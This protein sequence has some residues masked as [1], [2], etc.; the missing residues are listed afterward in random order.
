MNQKKVGS[1]FRLYMLLIGLL[2]TGTAW[3]QL[4]TGESP[5]FPDVPPRASLIQISEPNAAQ[6]VTV[7]GAAGAVPGGN[8]VV[9]VT[10]DTGHMIQVMAGSDGSFSA[11][12]FAPPGTSIL[13]KTGPSLS[14]GDSILVALAGTILRVADPQFSGGGISFGGAGPVDSGTLPVWTFQGT[15]NSNRLQPG[16]AL[17][18]GGTLRIASEALRDASA[19][20][21]QVG[22]SMERLSGPDGVGSLAKNLYSSVF[23]TPTGLPIEMTYNG[24]FTPLSQ[25][26]VL[27]L[28]KVE[29]DK[30][31]AIADLL[32][33]L[34][35]DLPAGYYRPYVA[36]SFEGVPAQEAPNITLIGVDAAGRVPFNN[37]NIRIS[38]YLPIVRIGEPA[39]PGL[40]WALLTDTL[41]NGTRGVRAIEDRGRFG[42]ASRILTQSE[43]FIVPRADAATGEPFTYRLEPFLPTISLGDRGTPPNPPLI[44][45]RIPSGSLTTRIRKPDGSVDT[46]GPAPFVQARVRGPVDSGGTALGR[47]G[48]HITDAYQLS[49]MDPSFEV[50]FTQEGRHVITLEGS[51]EDV[52]GNTW[53][54][55]GTY[56]VYVARILSLDTAVLPGTPFEAGNFF[57]SGL[58]VQ[59][60]VPAE[61]E[62]RFRLAPHSD[63]TQA[64]ERIVR[65]RANRLGYYL[66]A[67]GELLLDQPGEYRVDLKASYRDEQGSLWMGARSWGGVVA[68]RNPAIIA[69]GRRGV[70][71]QPEIGAQ[72]FFRTETGIPIGSSHVPYAFHTGDV[73]WLQGSDAVIPIVTFQDT[74][75]SF[76]DL[77]TGRLHPPAEG[78][79]SIEE[80]ATAGEVQLFSSRPDGLDPQ[81]DPS[82]VDLWGYFYASVQRPLVRVREEIRQEMAATG[83]YW[84]FNE[85]FGGQAGVGRNGDLPND[86]KFQYGA[87]VLRGAALEEPQYA[88]YAS[89]F[90]LIPDDD[91]S[92]GT[93]TFPPFQG[94][95]GGPSGG[96]VMTLK[97]REIDIFFHPTGVRPGS[98]LEAGGIASFAG[99]IA[100][101]LPSKVE[102]TITAPGGEIREV[103]GQANKIGYFYDPDM[104]FIVEEAGP[105]RVKVKVWHDGLTSA[106]PV[107]EPFPAG[108]VLGASQGEFFFYVVEP[109]SEELQVGIARNSFVRPAEGPIQ[110]SISP[111]QEPLEAVEASRLQNAE[112]HFTTVMPGFILEEG[113]STELSYSYDAPRLH[114]DFPNLDLFDS[115]G[116]AGADTVT[117]SFLI[118]GT[119]SQGEMVYQARQL[120]LQGEELMALP[121]RLP[122]EGFAQFGDGQGLS[123][124]LILVNP[125]PLQTALGKAELV[126]SEGGAL[127]ADINGESGKSRFSFEVSPLGA[128][129][130]QTDGEGDLISGSALL[131]SNIPLGGTVLFSGDLGVAGVGMVRP[132][133]HFTVPLE[134]QASQGVETGLALANPADA[135]VVVEVVLR[136][137]DGSQIGRSNLT[138]AARGQLAKFP[139]EIFPGTDLSS[140]RGSLQV[141]SPQPIIGMAIRVSPGQFATLPVASPAGGPTTRRFAQFGDGDGISSTM[142]LVN[143]FEEETSGT[144]RL[145]ASDGSPLLVEINGKPVEGAFSFSLPARGVAFFAGDGAGDLAAGWV[146]VESDLQIG[147]TIL[148]AGGFGV[149]GVGSVEAARRFLLPVESDPGSE[150]QTG[151]ALANPQDSAVEVAL[152]LRGE[153]GKPITGGSASLSL[154]ARGQLAQFP[155]EI[156]DAQLIDL[157]NFRGTLEVSASQPVVGMA[158][159]VSPGE[160]AT[161]PVTRMN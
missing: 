142:I 12:I 65:G 149:A 54:G 122:I 100:P 55:G 38:M 22:L 9:L 73:M 93:R 143:P 18:V 130:Y 15:I 92:G 44:P 126:S 161:L 137:T 98:I 4:V 2:F 115:D 25:N 147:G 105:Y 66:P 128:G 62:L 154:P 26:V 112:L 157:S 46:L 85:W 57:H 5:L 129:F 114:E 77:L 32:L 111:A 19:M 29:A 95:A 30:G 69:H 58:A 78:P 158:I 79:G 34:P 97:G 63:A 76:A 14:E 42:L 89:L 50:Q 120:L 113:R 145:F 21:V 138:L 17:E 51:I 103:R 75:G 127:Q 24:L 144:V 90:V 10:L 84:R 101:P 140:F 99:Q 71:D 61:V 36:F 68:P 28:I 16:D 121:H 116:R 102:I 59:P 56:E 151:V 43:T 106:G 123:S 11:S 135:Q 109:G 133:K 94:A 108:D 27:D 7:N 39:A 41:S 88:V 153:D 40:F 96:A 60:P 67:Q 64:V 86:I 159:R 74:T 156:F 37:R 1:L 8:V 118:S 160:F 48:G 91:P 35:V 107:Q 148:F 52:W 82:R 131:Q 117:M 47:G 13:I 70:D 80:R 49:T 110:I 33:P 124:S 3:P 125:S 20:R 83:A 119:D 150:V 134:S 141:S 132:E 155:S 6:E 146:E 139:R 152:T 53:R 31:E 81:I 87:A 23:L 136:R 104:D 72:W 45:F